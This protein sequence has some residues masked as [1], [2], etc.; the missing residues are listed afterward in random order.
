MRDIRLVRESRAYMHLGQYGEEGCS[1]KGAAVWQR[2]FG[3]M[4]ADGGAEGGARGE[5]G[6]AVGGADC[7]S[8]VDDT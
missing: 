4:E 2:V 8:A 7:A 3:E 5:A 6:A 1:A